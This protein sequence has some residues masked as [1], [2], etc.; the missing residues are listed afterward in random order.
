VGSGDRDPPYPRPGFVLGDAKA[1]TTKQ[2]EI[3]DS[4]GD[5]RGLDPG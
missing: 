4:T 3:G 5:L 2:Q 1:R